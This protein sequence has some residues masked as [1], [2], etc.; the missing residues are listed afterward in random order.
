MAGSRGQYK[1]SASAQNLKSEKQGAVWTL[2]ASGLHPW[3]QPLSQAWA[4]L[5]MLFAKEM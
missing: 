4:P 5:Q 1:I 3:V 2:I